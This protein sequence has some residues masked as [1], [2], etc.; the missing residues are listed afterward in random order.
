MLIYPLSCEKYIAFAG[1]QVS[2]T[3]VKKN[4][5]LWFLADLSNSGFL[6]MIIE[7]F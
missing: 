3:Y 7:K 5:Q 1:L 6:K 2:G 4:G